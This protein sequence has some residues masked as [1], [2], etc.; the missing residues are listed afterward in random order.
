MAVLLVVMSLFFV[1]IGAKLVSIQA[2]SSNR[3][4]SVGLSQRM[5]SVSLPGQRGSIFDRN[6]HEIAV[7]VPQTTIWANPHQVTDPRAEAIQLS[8]LLGIDAASLQLKLSSSPQ[9]VYLA[10]KV[11][12][13]L[14]AKVAALKLPGVFAMPEPKR[15]FPDGTLAA[16]LIGAVGLDNAGLSGIE[17]EYNSQ[18]AGRPGKLMEERDPAGS[19]IPGGFRQYQP[20]VNGEDLVLTIDQSLQ[21]KA[22]QTLAAAIVTAKA[23]SGIAMVMDTKTGE[24]LAVANMVAPAPPNPGVPTQ[25][26]PVASTA[27]SAF[28]DVF[29]PG[30]V[31]KLMT[32]SAALETGVVVPSDR[33]SV[34]DSVPL[35][36]AVF[37]DAES[38]PVQNWSVT[39]IL[40]NSS[41]VGTIGIA[42]KLGKDRLDRYLHA[43]GFGQPTPVRFPGESAGLAPAVAQWSATSIGTIA[44]GQGVAVTAAQML[45]AYN[46]IANG[47]VYVA[48]K[49]LAATV[50]A[51]G[52][53]HAT[54]PSPEHRV[55][56]PLVAQQ[57]TTMLGEVVRVGTGQLAKVDGYT[58]AGKTGTARIPLQGA[59]GYMDGVYMSSFAGFVP[60]EAPALTSIVVLDRSPDFG[61]AVAAP[62]FSAISGYTLRQLRIPPPAVAP[63]AAGVPLATPQTAQ[64]AGEVISRGA[65]AA[66]TTTVIPRRSP[67]ITVPVKGTNPPSPA[68]PPSSAPGTTTSTS[69]PA[70]R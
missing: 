35:A 16:P 58:V 49:L 36:D 69:R 59:R 23:R 41:N 39:D 1:A 29:E 2:I 32:I 46:A 47:G 27:A 22:E 48:P 19:P 56:S 9:F 38:H 66:G 68:T 6:G 28:T 54:P 50:D 67:P 8:G 60:A 11:D 12:D 4:L 44:I 25:G 17:K 26:Q 15:F 40:T 10:R 30:S 62:V 55:V 63:P 45:A 33:F 5:T 57:M 34:P 51:N 24:L 52:Q 43:F 65:K 3:Y 21:A 31:S 18:L 53:T 37:R 64:G 14:A 42:Q 20:A 61:G 70:R 7:S 13:A